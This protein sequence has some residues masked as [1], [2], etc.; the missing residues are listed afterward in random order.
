MS[1]NNWEI[2]APKINVEIEGR[3]IYLKPLCMAEVNDVYLSWLNDPEI[4]EFLEVRHRKQTMEDICAYINYTRGQNK[5][6]VFGIFTKK[7]N[8]HVGNIAIT[9]G[10]RNGHEKVFSFGIMVGCKR[11]QKIGVGAEASILIIDFLFNYLDALK[12]EDGVIEG[13]SKSWRMLE[14]LGFKKEGVLRKHSRLTSGDIR[15]VF[16]YG[17]IR[18]DWDNNYARVSLILKDMKVKENNSYLA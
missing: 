6:E 17:M 16:L 7:D 1:G 10:H 3:T 12:I 2:I 9:D 14:L 5:R 11:A 18:E 13:N 15:D 8:R 4:N